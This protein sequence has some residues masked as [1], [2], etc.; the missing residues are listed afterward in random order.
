MKNHQT[1]NSE[2]PASMTSP[3]TS[4]NSRLAFNLG[5]MCE[6]WCK[7]VYNITEVIESK[8][9]VNY[10]VEC[11]LHH[12]N[13]FYLDTVYG[14]LLYKNFR[15]KI[16]KPSD[17][18]ADIYS[19][20]YRKA[21]PLA[22]GFVNSADV[23]ILCLTETNNNGFP[24]IRNRLT[25]LEEIHNYEFCVMAFYQKTVQVPQW[26]PK[27]ILTLQDSGLFSELMTILNLTHKASDILHAL[28]EH[29]IYSY[30]API[31]RTTSTQC[32]KAAANN[33][34]IDSKRD[35]AT[36]SDLLKSIE[37]IGLMNSYFSEK[38]I[39]YDRN[40]Q[41][42]N[43]FRSKSNYDPL[44]RSKSNYDPLG[45]DTECRNSCNSHHTTTISSFDDFKNFLESR[46]FDEF[47]YIDRS[48]LQGHYDCCCL[49]PLTGYR[50]KHSMVDIDSEVDLGLIST[51]LTYT[52]VI[53]KNNCSDIHY[54][55]SG[56][57]MINKS[58]YKSSLNNLCY[59][60]YDP[61]SGL[62]YNISAYGV[63]NTA[64]TNMDYMC[65][66]S[67][68]VLPLL[69]LHR[70]GRDYILASVDM[71][72]N[73]EVPTEN[74]YVGWKCNH[75]VNS[76]VK[77]NTGDNMS[78]INYYN[79]VVLKKI[80]YEHKGISKPWSMA[81]TGKLVRLP[82]ISDIRHYLKVPG[83]I[84][85]KSLLRQL[86]G[87]N[88]T[89]V[90][91]VCEMNNQKPIDQGVNQSP[92]NIIGSS[93]HPMHCQGDNALNVFIHQLLSQLT[94]GSFPEAALWKLHRSLSGHKSFHNGHSHMDE[95][96]SITCKPNVHRV[97]LSNPDPNRNPTHNLNPF[98]KILDGVDPKHI[99]GSGAT[100]Q[101]TNIFNNMHVRKHS[102]DGFMMGSGHLFVNIRDDPHYDDSQED[103]LYN[104][105]EHALIKIAMDTSSLKENQT[106]MYDIRSSI[107]RAFK[108][109]LDNSQSWMSLSNIKRQELFAR[110]AIEWSLDMNDTYKPSPHHQVKFCLT[111]NSLDICVPTTRYLDKRWFTKSSRNETY[112]LTYKNYGVRVSLDEYGH[113]KYQSGFNRDLMCKY[114]MIPSQESTMNQ[115]MS[116]DSEYCGVLAFHEQG[117]LEADVT[118]DRSDDCDNAV[119]LISFKIPRFNPT[120][121]QITSILLTLDRKQRFC[122]LDW[123]YRLF[124]EMTEYIAPPQSKKKYAQSDAESQ[125]D[126]VHTV[127][128]E[129]IIMLTHRIGPILK[130]IWDKARVD[131]FDFL[132]PWVTHFIKYSISDAIGHPFFIMPTIKGLV[133]GL[134]NEYGDQ[135]TCDC[136]YWPNQPKYVVN[137]LQRLYLIQKVMQ[138]RN[139]LLLVCIPAMPLYS[140]QKLSFVKDTKL[141]RST[142]DPTNVGESRS[143]SYSADD[144]SSEEISSVEGDV[145]EETFTASK[146][147]LYALEMYYAAGH[148]SIYPDW[149]NIIKMYDSFKITQG[150]QPQNGKSTST[151]P[152]SSHSC[153]TVDHLETKILPNCQ[154]CMTIY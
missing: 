36:F 143:E 124:D 84:M 43:V 50:S 106:I 25:M 107:V 97:P 7:A 125:K 70:N 99:S 15:I 41:M 116:D 123:L 139:I 56:C 112:N 30:I 8:Y 46:F 69:P 64:V 38:S 16:I 28:T 54:A 92:S 78:V 62:L 24:S 152:K 4:T 14:F 39:Q 154:S 82:I 79:W 100:S 134:V 109:M 21:H 136:C 40:H 63:T 103:E 149:I 87:I 126:R 142:H 58:A 88:V 17:M 130:I 75:N 108:K 93:A 42:F 113:T 110:M 65:N 31:L 111:L 19:H 71:I 96:N 94:T 135:R 47:L 2:P 44:F 144:E 52:M 148:E 91:S 76:W 132:F 114:N 86:I 133:N 57:E 74:Q 89:T 151:A 22:L 23:R 18:S 51:S 127:I 32:D 145:L 49:N 129:I 45:K 131:Y 72:S 81:D 67:C 61:I 119:T 6:L 66:H 141:A 137:I 37:I 20:I 68:T 120:T 118:V 29:C 13:E 138:P 9:Q 95:R 85:V 53:Y 60:L 153:K 12:R 128:K 26:Q 80:R 5:Y 140:I 77:Y 104:Y 101:W 27:Q 98:E 3:L 90:C 122:G 48:N 35:L 55:L 10:L 117:Q 146:Y 105:H 34:L 121:E 1:V 11:L 59:D 115:Y 147:V 33:P 83:Y 73:T 102:N 150:D